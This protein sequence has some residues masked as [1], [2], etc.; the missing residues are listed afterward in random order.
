M[1]VL[2]AQHL[3]NQRHFSEELVFK[4]DHKRRLRENTVSFRNKDMAAKR[5][6]LPCA[7][8]G[9]TAI[10][11]RNVDGAD[12]MGLFLTVRRVKNSEKKQK[13]LPGEPARISPLDSLRSRL[14]TALSAMP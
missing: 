12:V 8:C 3:N 5:R 2:F 4:F 10:T 7:H 1:Q 13:K 9:R 11:R 14:G 6:E